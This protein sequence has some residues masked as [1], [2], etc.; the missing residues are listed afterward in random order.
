MVELN[1]DGMNDS[2][3]ITQL[4]NTPGR[5]IIVMEDID[6]SL[7]SKNRRIQIQKKREESQEYGHN[8]KVTLSGVLNA[9]DGLCTADS[10]IVIMTTNFIKDLDP[11]LIRPGRLVK[12]IYINHQN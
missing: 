3:L 4:S 12:N 5:S 6:V 10:Q 9:L 8:S 1:S 11:A 2:Q 7:P